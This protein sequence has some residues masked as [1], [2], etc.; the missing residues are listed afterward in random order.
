MSFTLQQK[1]LKLFQFK[2]ILEIRLL[3]RYDATRKAFLM[4]NNDELYITYF[5][6]DFKLD[7]ASSELLK[8]EA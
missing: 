5:V 1:L 6:N 7:K 4:I 3:S 8:S 2:Q